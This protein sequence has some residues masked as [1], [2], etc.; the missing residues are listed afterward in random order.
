MAVG[1][2]LCALHFG[3]GDEPAILARNA[4]RL[5]AR[6]VNPANKFFVDCARQDHFGNLCGFGIRDAKAINKFALDA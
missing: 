1:V 4:K 6:S 5:A 3:C 2:L